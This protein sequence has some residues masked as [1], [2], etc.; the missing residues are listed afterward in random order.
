MFEGCPADDTFPPSYAIQTALRHGPML[1]HMDVSVICSPRSQR[2][3]LDLAEKKGIK[4]QDSVREGGGNDAAVINTALGGIPSVVAGVPVRYIHSMNGI[5]T[6]EDFESSVQL[7]EAVI[8]SMT[9]ET[10][11]SF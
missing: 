5:C 1:R 8:R 6:L 10:I 3:V 4:A 11:S 9:P 2:Y 7:A